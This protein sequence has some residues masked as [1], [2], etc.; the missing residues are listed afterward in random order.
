MAKLEQLN[1]S[2]PQHRKTLHLMT[3]RDQT[4]GSERKCCEVC[5]RPITANMSYTSTDTLYVR[6]EIDGRAYTPCGD[7]KVTEE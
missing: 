2:E 6:L 3:Q 7:I 5:G 1:I 4:Y